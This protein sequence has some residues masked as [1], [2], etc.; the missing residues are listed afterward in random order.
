MRFTYRLRCVLSQSRLDVYSFHTQLV[1]I[2]TFPKMLNCSV[3]CIPRRHIIFVTVALQ[4]QSRYRHV[5]ISCAS[6]NLSVWILSIHS[7]TW[8]DV[9]RCI[10]FRFQTNVRACISLRHVSTSFPCR[11]IFWCNPYRYQRTRNC[12]V[13]RMDLQAF[14]QP[15]Q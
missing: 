7:A 14:P 3:I 2:R 15:H 1:C 5:H 4:L 10:P 12:N 9:F 13:C 11:H 6:L 8:L